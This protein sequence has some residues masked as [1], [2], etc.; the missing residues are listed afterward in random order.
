MGIL[1]FRAKQAYE[2]G[3]EVGAQQSSETEEVRQNF[4]V[5]NT[6]MKAH[7][8]K[9]DSER[10]AFIDGYGEGWYSQKF[11]GAKAQ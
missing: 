8:L 5:I 10:T 1:S 9:R 2:T 3:V 4:E 11:G 6:S 7:G